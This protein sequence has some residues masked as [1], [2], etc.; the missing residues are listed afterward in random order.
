MVTAEQ[1]TLFDIPATEPKRVRT[2]WDE[3]KEMLSVEQDLVPHWVA[4]ILLDVSRQRVNELMSAGRIRTY[5]FFGRSFVPVEDL[6]SYINSERKAGRP[7]GQPPATLKET[8]GRVKK[9]R[10]EK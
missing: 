2:K 10:S 8:I 4:P 3:L 5:E 1:Y 9:M 6:V 7:C